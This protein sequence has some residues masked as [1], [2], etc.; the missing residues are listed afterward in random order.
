MKNPGQ[1]E[2]FSPE[3]WGNNH[4]CMLQVND[5]IYMFYHTPQHEIDLNMN[6]DMSNGGSAYRTTYV[7]VASLKGNGELVVNDMT[8]C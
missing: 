7:D 5:T 3:A 2:Y 1:S 8:T 6:F 4:H